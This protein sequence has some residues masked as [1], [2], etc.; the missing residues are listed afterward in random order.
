MLLEA[1][2]RYR[3][4]PFTR[5]AEGDDVVIGRP[6]TLTFLAVSPDIV[7]ILDW[8]DD[9]KSLAEARGLY[10]GVF[11][12]AEDLSGA[13][14]VLAAKGFLLP[15]SSEPPLAVGAGSG[16]GRSSGKVLTGLLTPLSMLYGP[17]GLALQGGLIALACGL[18]WLDSSLAPGLRALFFQRHVTLTS[19]TVIALSLGTLAWHE[20]AHMAAAWRKGVRARFGVSHRLWMVVAE[21]DLSRLWSLPRRERFLPI[22]AGPLADGVFCAA[23][24]IL[25]FA[26]RRQWV[27]FG[28]LSRTVLEAILVISVLRILWQCLLFVRTDF[29][30][31]LAHLLGCRNL[32]ADTETYLAGL[33]QF[34]L[35]RSAA[36]DLSRL[37]RHERR[38]V[39]AYGVLWILGRLLAI[40]FLVTVQ[41]PLLLHFLQLFWRTLTAEPARTYEVI[42]TSIMALLLLLSNG[43]GFGLWIRSHVAAKRRSS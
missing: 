2:S 29:Y 43:L 9:G 24:V 39:R 17:L 21:T 16:D 42:D 6:D 14:E 41:I 25:L 11:G 35:R 32:M 27:H 8:L 26:E 31:A 28:S 23:V 38:A 30:Y 4:L 18:L 40:G 37:V 10:E 20:L 33:A 3:V 34:A 15:W 12:S 19:A 1:E 36:P 13:I 22:L 7:A 5:V